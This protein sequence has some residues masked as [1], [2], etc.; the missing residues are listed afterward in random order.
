MPKFMHI[1][2]LAVLDG[3]T[4]DVFKENLEDTA[5]LLVDETADA[6]DSATAGQAV[7]GWLHNNI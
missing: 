3:I 6:L 4:D 1:I 7:D 5:G 2:F